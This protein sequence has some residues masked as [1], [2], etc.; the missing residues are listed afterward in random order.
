MNDLM[1]K[2]IK[3]CMTCENK[4]KNLIFIDDGFFKLETSENMFH[5]NNKWRVFDV[6]SEKRRQEQNYVQIKTH[7]NFGIRNAG[8]KYHKI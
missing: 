2:L 3:F 5:Y 1:S 4:Y 6:S 7:E 8:S